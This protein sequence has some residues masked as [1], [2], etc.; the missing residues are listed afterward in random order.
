MNSSPDLGLV[1]VTDHLNSENAAY[2]A[3]QN[4]IDIYEEDSSRITILGPTST[5]IQRKNV[6]FQ[7]IQRE[8]PDNPILRIVEHIYYQLQLAKAVYDARA[9]LD[10]IFF[11]LGGRVLLFPLVVCKITSIPS[12]VFVTGSIKQSYSTN[13]DKGFRSDLVVRAIDILEDVTNKLVDRVIL[14]SE[15]MQSNDR[16]IP[17]EKKV[18]ANLNYINREKF[19]RERP[20][21]NRFYDIVFVGRLERVKGVENLVQALPRLVEKHPQLRVNLIGDGN[22]RGELQT[23]VKQEGLS[24]HVEFSGW[25]N[26]DELPNH[27][28]EGRLL[29]LPSESEGVPKAMLEAMACG[30]VPVATPVG[31][32]PDIIESEENGFLID[33]N[34]PD[35][36]AAVTSEVLTEGDLDRVSRNAQRYVSNEYSF[37]VIR[38]KYTDILDGLGVSGTRN[39]GLSNYFDWI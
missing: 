18:T 27:L 5:T 32:I 19:V 37:E 10:V 3:V 15:S 34:D 20:I 25:I 12:A 2:T 8:I 17:S 39:Q 21:D 36:I 13:H 26:H 1:L 29:V 24:D 31:G 28:N 11:H 33:N 30:T 7:L 6:D 23:Y 38:E 9:R 16:Y 22:L 14:L 4:F 35:E